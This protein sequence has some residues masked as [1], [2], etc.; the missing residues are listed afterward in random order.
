MEGRQARLAEAPQD[1]H[2]EWARGAVPQELEDFMAATA[3]IVGAATFDLRVGLELGTGRSGVWRMYDYGN[4]DCLG[5]EEE[6]DRCAV[7]WVGHDPWSVIFVCDSLLAYVNDLADFAESTEA[8]MD[9]E[10]PEEE[11]LWKP[12]V[13]LVPK[14]GAD[15]PA[16]KLPPEAV[17]YD[18]TN[19]APRSHADLWKIPQHAKHFEQARTGRY[20]VAQPRVEVAVPPGVAAAA[21]KVEEAIAMAM[22]ELIPKAHA[23]LDEALVLD[24][25]HARALE[26]KEMLKARG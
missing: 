15:F 17:V 7:W 12:K 18:F 20:L 8:T 19:C 10:D 1:P 26:W 2:P 16:L 24:P 25:G 6:G 5:I 11:L 9:E 4:G 14:T 13:E 3:G 22:M 21:A 23:L